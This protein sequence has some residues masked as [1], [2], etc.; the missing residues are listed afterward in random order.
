MKTVCVTGASG[1]VGAEIVRQLLARGYAVKATARCEADS[2]KL[3]HLVRE[4]AVSPG[5]LQLCQVSRHSGGLVGPVFGR[6]RRK[7]SCMDAA[8]TQ[9]ASLLGPSVELDAAIEGATY[10][11][12]VASPFR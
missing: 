3:A 11:F 4:A 6:L 2:P 5:T 9:V 8:C 7:P 1:F 12:H 10:I